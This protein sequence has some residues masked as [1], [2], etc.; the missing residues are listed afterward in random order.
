MKILLI[1][2]YPRFKHGIILTTEHLKMFV[3]ILDGNN[4]DKIV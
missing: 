2:I 4:Y 1:Y 3:V